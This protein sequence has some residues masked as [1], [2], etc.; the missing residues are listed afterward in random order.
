M[1]VNKVRHTLNYTGL[2]QLHNLFVCFAALLVN[3]HDVGFRIE[4]LGHTLTSQWTSF[5]RR[6]DS[7]QR[8]NMSGRFSILFGKIYI[9]SLPVFRFGWDVLGLAFHSVHIPINV[10][11]RNFGI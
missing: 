11:G 4:S 2:L 10:T 6:Y 3:V 9:W 1:F 7:R 8:F 5:V